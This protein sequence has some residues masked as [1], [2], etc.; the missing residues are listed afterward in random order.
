MQLSGPG[1]RDFTS[2]ESPFARDRTSNAKSAS[3]AHTWSGFDNAGPG[4]GA[5]ASCLTHVV[6]LGASASELE[7]HVDLC[8]QWLDPGPVSCSP[9]RNC[10]WLSHKWHSTALAF[11]APWLPLICMHVV[12]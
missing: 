11:L 5:E 12:Q 8:N 10:S 7:V 4:A 3:I 2:R 6:F 9:L 1:K